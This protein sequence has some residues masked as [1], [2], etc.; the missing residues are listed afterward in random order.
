MAGQQPE[1]DMRADAHWSIEKK[2]SLPFIFG[3]IVQTSVIVGFVYTLNFR[4]SQVEK[5]ADEYR[6]QIEKIIRI[7]T[8]VDDIKERLSGIETIL[9]TGKIAR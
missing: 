4:V 5:V 9:R 3:V 6:P 1:H 2:L 7:E 8:K